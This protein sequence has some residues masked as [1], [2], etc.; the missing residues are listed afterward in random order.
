[1]HT[2]VTGQK[3][4]MKINSGEKKQTDYKWQNRK[5]NQR[6]VNIDMGSVTGLIN[7][8]VGS[9]DRSINTEEKKKKKERKEET[10]RHRI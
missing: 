4:Y 8:E 1:M 9:V 7:I 5:Q 10:Q 6:K 2:I 3:E